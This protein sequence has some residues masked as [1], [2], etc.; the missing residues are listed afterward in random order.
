V[1]VVCRL[2]KVRARAQGKTLKRIAMVLPIFYIDTFKQAQ[3]Q[4]AS[5]KG[6]YMSFTN[7]PTKEHCTA[8]LHILLCQVLTGCD[9]FEAVWTMIIEPM[10]LLER[11]IDIEFQGTGPTQCYSSM[12]TLLG[13][14]LLQ[15][16]LAGMFLFVF[17]LCHPRCLTLSLCCGSQGWEG[18][19][20][21]CATTATSPQCSS[22]T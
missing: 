20:G 3:S 21:R 13:D 15:A 22:C 6:I 8:N 19:D 9:I 7:T 12:Y 14:H 2:F 17:A 11:G 4:H 1:A 10:H 18:V 5:V 16:K